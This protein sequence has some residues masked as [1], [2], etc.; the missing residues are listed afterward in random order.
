VEDAERE[1][2]LRHSYRLATQC[3]CCIDQITR[4]V[5]RR[6]RRSP[7]TILH[8]LRKHDLEHPQ[9]A[10]LRLAAAPIDGPE[11]AAITR[12]YRHRVGIGELAR[13]Y[14]SPQSAIYHII[15]QD[16]ASRLLK[17]KMRFYDDPLYHPR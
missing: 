1:Q 16:R 13:L 3:G 10:I 15:L 17:R 11:R 6:V 12:G 14:G 9:D 4:R 8:T 2:I 5:G 7:L